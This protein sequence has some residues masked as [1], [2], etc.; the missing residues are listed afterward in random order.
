VTVAIGARSAFQPNANETEVLISVHLNDSNDHRLGRERR[1]L[2]LDLRA[3]TRDLQFDARRT[4][5]RNQ[6][7]LCR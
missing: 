3:R 5:L 1:Q 6:T 7:S 2:G 4:Q